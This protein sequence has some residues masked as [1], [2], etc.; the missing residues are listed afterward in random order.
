VSAV[1]NAYRKCRLILLNFIYTCSKQ[2]NDEEIEEFSQR[3]ILK[4]ALELSKTLVASIPYHLTRNPEIFV[5]QK[6]MSWTDQAI[7]P[8]HSIG[9]LMLIYTLHAVL[10]LSIVPSHFNETFREYLISIG[11]VMG[12]GQASLLADVSAYF[13]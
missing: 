5:N 4:E 12:I 3:H 11:S 10:D 9:G 1:W 2:L 13:P 7:L 8:N 6:Q